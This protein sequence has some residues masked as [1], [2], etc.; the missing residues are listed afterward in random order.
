MWKGR[1]GR[2]GKEGGGGV[3]KGKGKRRG[4]GANAHLLP[5]IDQPLLHGWDAL[6]LLHAF[7]YAGDLWCTKRS[8][9]DLGRAFA[10][11][12]VGEGND[13]CKHGERVDWR[14]WG[15]VYKIPTLYSGSISS[16]ISLPVR[17]RTLE[18]LARCLVFDWRR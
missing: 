14:G 2:C 16:S 12:W 11:A 3:E 13:D 9:S 1:R 6:F 5:T 4:R 8:I 17:V 15:I 7:L 10:A 18:V